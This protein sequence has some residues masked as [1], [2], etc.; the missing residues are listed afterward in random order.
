M[1]I[2]INTMIFRNLPLKDSLSEIA[3]MGYKY[4]EVSLPHFSV[5]DATQKELQDLKEWLQTLG[6]KLA[7]FFETHDLA[8]LDEEA[9]RE[10]VTRMKQT[11]KKS[12]AFGCNLITSEM[13]GVPERRYSCTEAFI[14]SVRE[15]IPILEETGVHISFEPHP[16]DFVEQSNAAVD[17]LREIN[18]KNIG[19]LYCIPHTFIMGEDP[20]NM[21]EYA[22]DILSY[23][24]VADSY[25]WDKTFFRGAIGTRAAYE[26][27]IKPHQHLIPGM[28]D[29]D[30]KVIFRTLKKIG[31]DGFITA[32]PFS[33][34]DRPV[35][36]AAETKKRIEEY[37]RSI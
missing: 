32:Q 34:Y 29:I 35:E 1:K 21:I 14:K 18:H 17:I 16:G 27:T 37:L 2:A 22:K 6:L 11:I 20:V 5:C 9:R 26:P 23:V 15:L 30:F 13:S 28:G 31:Y 10:G 36:A 8:A 4:V 3:K 19:Y 24:H 25:K 12:H 7:S 33:H